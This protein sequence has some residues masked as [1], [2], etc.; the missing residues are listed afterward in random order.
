MSTLDQ[1]TTATVFEVA[2]KAPIT[3]EQIA[4]VNQCRR[5]RGHA[6]QVGAS[7]PL[8]GGSGRADRA[9][10]AYT[11]DEPV[12]VGDVVRVPATFLM[13]EADATVVRLGTTY[14]KPLTGIVRIVHSQADRTGGAP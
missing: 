3:A 12:A 14:D 7:C 1:P 13:P 4:L 10:Y 5:C 11:S 8:C 9:G 2:Y 6:A